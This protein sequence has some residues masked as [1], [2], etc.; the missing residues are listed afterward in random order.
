MRDIGSIL[1]AA[2]GGAFLAVAIIFAAANTGYLP[3]AATGGMTDARI[4][5]YLLAHPQILSEMT[6]LAQAQAEAADEAKSAAAIKKIG[7]KTFFDPSVAFVTGPENA[8]TSIVEFYDYDCPYCRASL[9]AMERF[10]E[11]HKSDTR[12]SFIEFPIPSLHGPGADLAAMV[13]L[14]ARRQPDKYVPLH[15]ALMSQKEQLD[16]ATIYA[17]A[18]QVGLDI[19]KLKEDV[20]DPI[21]AETLATSKNLAHQAGINGTPTF[22]INGVMHPG[23]VDDDELKALTKTS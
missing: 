21:I 11:K 10:Y 8:K 6:D 12:F 7:L 19:K 16:E 1:V 4:R 22:I 20:K 15:F 3:A 13:S 17:V 2:L 23:A 5:G 14:A 9:P 18:A